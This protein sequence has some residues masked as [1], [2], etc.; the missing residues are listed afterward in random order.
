MTP[1]PKFDRQG[2]KYL[3]LK[4]LLP[5][6]IRVTTQLSM[7]AGRYFTSRAPSPASNYVRTQSYVICLT[8]DLFA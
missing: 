7:L 6:C 1:E 4:V 8:S 2:P 5:G 3:R